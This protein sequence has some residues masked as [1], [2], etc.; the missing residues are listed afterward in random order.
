VSTTTKQLT[1]I[2]ILGGGVIE[3]RDGKYFVKAAI[4]EYLYELRKYFRKVLFITVVEEGEKYISKLDPDVVS[5]IP[6]GESK[7]STG[8]I[9]IL[10]DF[11]KSFWIFKKK[12]NKNTGVLISG[13]Y[14]RVLGRIVLAKLF[15]GKVIYYLGSDP[16]LIGRLRPKNLCGFIKKILWRLSFPFAAL[17]S[18][19]ILVRGKSILLQV[20]RW[21]KNAILSKPIIA[22]S[23]ILKYQRKLIRKKKSFINILF[24]GKLNKNKGIDILI[25]AFAKLLK[26]NKYRCKLTIVGTGEE[27]ETF[28]CLTLELGIQHSVQFTG[29]IDDMDIL[30]SYYRQSDIFVVPSVKTEG[31]PRVIEEAM[32]CG[33][34]VICSKLGGMKEEF[35]DNDVIFVTPGSIDELYKAMRKLI[36]DPNY[37]DYLRKKSCKKAADIISMTAAEQHARFVIQ[38]S[39]SKIQFK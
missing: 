30:F 24:V 21:N 17:L 7:R 35:D 11:W 36:S 26:E 14:V 23:F 22:Y 6:F 31:L 38:F 15:A 29:Y 10:I 37:F 1:R 28:E 12:L 9:D 16:L 2:C 32:L 3:Q 33:L 19:G 27:I 5:I 39:H 25:K 8:I 20:R 18:D 34:P 4:G 13:V